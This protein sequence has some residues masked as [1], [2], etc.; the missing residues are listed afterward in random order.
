M[1]PKVRFVLVIAL[2]NAIRAILAN[3]VL[4]AR[5]SETFHTH[6][7]Q[8]FINIAWATLAVIVGSELPMLIAWAN[9]PTRANGV[10]NGKANVAAAV[11]PTPEP[12]V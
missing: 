4:M 9:S 6:T 5:F 12:K 1:N 8:G 10:A 11:A 3:S 7:A 2:K